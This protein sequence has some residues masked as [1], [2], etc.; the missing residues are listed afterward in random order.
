MAEQLI[1]VDRKDK[2]IGSCTKRACHVG[3]GKLHRSFSIF[4]FNSKGQ[5][6]LQ[7]RAKHKM[8]WPGYW[9][10][11]CCSHPRVGEPLDVAVHRKLKQ[12]MGFDCQLK[13][14]FSFVYK[15]RFGNKGCEYEFDHVFVG[16]WDGQPKPNARE[17]AEWK[18]EDIDKI[19]EDIKNTPNRYTP[20]FRLAFERAVRYSKEFKSYP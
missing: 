16:R 14:V 9:S 8:L 1:L 20:W 6:L 11:S 2:E 17:V 3:N 5:L 18:W 15:V 13:E 19:R 12:E 7:K 4:V 10:N